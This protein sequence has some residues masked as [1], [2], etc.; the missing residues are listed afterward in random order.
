[1]PNL[2]SNGAPQFPDLFCDDTLRLETRRLWLRWPAYSDAAR[3]HEI[4]S[5]E[6][7]A[8]P[9][10]TWP[11]PLPEGEALRRIEQARAAN[12]LGHS[13]VLAL[14]EKA[15]PDVLI[16]IIGVGGDDSAPGIVTA[17]Y[18]LGVQHQGY[19][20]M[21]EA[22]R[23]MANVVFRYTSFGAIRGASGLTNAASRRVMEKAGFRRIGQLSHAAPARGSK[24]ECDELELTR[25][26]WR[27]QPSLIAGP[28]G[29]T[30]GRENASVR[31]A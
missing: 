12:A 4:A 22:V 8:R 28:G 27:G 31:A 17:G 25:S 13:L 10:A 21:T 9:T 30:D 16:G 20:L 11:H 19:G 18:M 6:A 14:A 29:E 24:I 3:L 5:M 7:V 23:G 1:M 2:I 26:D 15:T